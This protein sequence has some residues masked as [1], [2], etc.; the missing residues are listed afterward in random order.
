M[1]SVTFE[2]P[3]LR[4]ERE[5]ARAEWRAEHRNYL[6]SSEAFELLNQP[7]YS[8][9]CATA[10][11]YRKLGAEP[12]YPEQTGDEALLERGNILEPLVAMLYE[13]QT[14]RKVRRPPMDEH[15]IP[16]P[17]RHHKYS[18]AGVN[19]DRLILSGPG[20]VTQTGDLEIKTRGEGAWMRIQRQG[21]LAGDILQPQW[22]LF[23]TGH[24]W[25]ALA[26]LGVFGGL[27]LSHF[28]VA[29]NQ[30][31]IS[32]FEREGEAFAD[33]VWGKGRVPAPAFPHTDQR[34]KVCAYRLT[35]RGE[36]IDR[37][38]VAVMREINKSAKDLVQITDA[39]L[40]HTLFDIELMKAERKALDE[41]IENAQSIALEQLGDT[42]AAIVHGFGKVYKMESQANY[43]DSQAI[44]L[45]E[46]ALYERYFVSRKTGEHFLR[47]YPT[48]DA[49]LSRKNA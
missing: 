6:G 24:E 22:S 39:A 30:E 33:E 43:L 36:E 32:I 49:L 40:T 19:T 25:G 26:T 11:A 14:G 44:K 2:R 48:K 1:A 38:E 15:G 35:C 37:A 20:G 21:P 31:L 8:R 12:D 28:D 45:N 17:R 3:K 18:W 41:S 34:C 16:I 13:Q 10:L 42:H 27:P 5:N 29:R 9:G 4:E 46:P 47:T 23:V 7:Q